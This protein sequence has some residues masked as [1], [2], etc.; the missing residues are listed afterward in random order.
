MLTTNG[1]SLPEL[2]HLDSTQEKIRQVLP[3]CRVSHERA[4]LGAQIREARALLAKSD[5]PNKQ[6]YVLTDMQRN[7]WES[8]GGAPVAESQAAADPALDAPLFV[9]DCSRAPRP[10]VAIHSVELKSTVPVSGVPV[11]ISVDLRNTSETDQQRLVE[12]VIEGTKK[13]QTSPVLNVPWAVI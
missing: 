9:V 13:E 11:T 2:D 5:A 8:A 3:Q 1:P 6:I 7:A 12:L 4:D 10:N